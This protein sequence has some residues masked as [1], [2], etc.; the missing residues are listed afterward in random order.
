MKHDWAGAASATSAFAASGA[1]IRTRCRASCT[2]CIAGCLAVFSAGG[3]AS[4]V[5]CVITRFSAAY[6]TGKLARSAAV[7]STVCLA[8]RHAL[9][10]TVIFA[11]RTASAGAG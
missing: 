2:R 9:R 3:A 10:V 5:A 4:T 7:A 8:G 1:I 6:D 11:S